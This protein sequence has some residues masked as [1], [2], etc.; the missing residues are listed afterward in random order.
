VQ[1]YPVTTCLFLTYL[2]IAVFGFRAWLRQYR[3]QLR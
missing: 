3:Q 1:G 2:T